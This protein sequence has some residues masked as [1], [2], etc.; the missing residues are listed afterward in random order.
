M[1]KAIISLRL[2]ENVDEYLAVRD[3]WDFLNGRYY[4]VADVVLSDGRYV[5]ELVFDGDSRI[6]VSSHDVKADM[7]SF[8]GKRIVDSLS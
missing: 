5:R 2:P 4:I 8:C 3:R 6:A 7:L 1:K